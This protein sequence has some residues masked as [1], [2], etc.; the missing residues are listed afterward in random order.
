MQKPTDF[1]KFNTDI[2]TV[3]GGHGDI[4][5]AMKTALARHM[6]VGA[7]LALCF[8]GN[9]DNLR[10]TAYVAGLAM[11][12]DKVGWEALLPCPDGSPRITIV[13]CGSKEEAE[14]MM[15][16]LNEREWGGLNG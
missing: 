5:D 13:E 16:A 2:L 8:E 7:G 9:Q 3:L 12:L 11:A 1:S 10:F 14:S 6:V 4:S 15:E